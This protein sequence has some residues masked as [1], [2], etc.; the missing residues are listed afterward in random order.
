MKQFSKGRG[1]I[2]DLRLPIADWLIAIPIQNR[3]LTICK[4]DPPAIAG[5]SD[6]T[7]KKGVRP[8][9]MG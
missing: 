6:V 8:T 7:A 3:Q 9:R 4:Q 2:V 1:M 5:G